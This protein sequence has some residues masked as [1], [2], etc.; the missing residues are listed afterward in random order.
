MLELEKS[1]NVHVRESELR[2]FSFAQFQAA[3]LE[4]NKNNKETNDDLK[5]NLQSVF[6]LVSEIKNMM[7]NRGQ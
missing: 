1:L 4:I 5:H 6:N 3:Q 2:V 7:I